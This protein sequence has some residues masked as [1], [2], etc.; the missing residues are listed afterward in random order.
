VLRELG[1][2]R[3]QL[4]AAAALEGELRGQLA[5]AEGARGATEE[6]LAREEAAAAAAR[7]EAEVLRAEG[8]AQRAAA[9]VERSR[10]EVGGCACARK[11]RRTA[12]GRLFI[13]CH[14][15]AEASSRLSSLVSRLMPS[16]NLGTFKQALLPSSAI[17]P[18]AALSA[19]EAEASSLT[20]SLSFLKTA[21][22]AAVAQKAEAEAAASREG[23]GRAALQR[24]RAAMA[25]QVWAEQSCG[26][27]IPH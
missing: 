2:A 24:E 13:G 8:E 4:A 6:A 20:D 11:E 26:A 17:A 14:G 15:L 21:L 16:P 10:L 5:A 3:E 19:R 22:A 25:N 1:L 7:S 12:Q 27:V 18:Q 9:E 23:V